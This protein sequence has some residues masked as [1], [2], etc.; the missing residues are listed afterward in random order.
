M[1]FFSTE[2]VQLIFTSSQ[3][4]IYPPL[5]SLLIILLSSTSL[6]QSTNPPTEVQFDENFIVKHYFVDKTLLL[7]ELFKD[8]GPDYN[9][10]SYPS[11]WGKTTTLQMIKRFAQIEIGKNRVPLNWNQTKA[12]QLFKNLKIARHP[13]V[14]EKHMARYAV[15]HLDLKIDIEEEEPINDDNVVRALNEVIRK[16]YFEYRWLVKLAKNLVKG[17]PKSESITDRALQG[18]L[19]QVEQRESILFLAQLLKDFF[20][21]NVLLLIDDYD[22]F[23]N[24]AFVSG[25]KYIDRYKKIVRMIVKKCFTYGNL[26]ISHA[27]IFG[28]SS[29]N[30]NFSSYNY[31]KV[32]HYELGNR[33]FLSD[34]RFGAFLGF[35]END[36]NTLCH[37]YQCT[38]EETQQLRLWY[39]G[40]LTRKLHLHDEETN[41]LKWMDVQT[42]GSEQRSIYN[43]YSITQYFSHRSSSKKMTPVF[44]N[45]WPQSQDLQF[46]YNFLRVPEFRDKFVGLFKYDGIEMPFDRNEIPQAFHQFTSMEIFNDQMIELQDAENLL[47]GFFFDSG[48]LCYSN[49]LYHVARIP[50]Y[51]IKHTLIEIL[52]DFYQK[53]N[54]PM[55]EIRDCFDRIITATSWNDSVIVASEAQEVLSRTFRIISKPYYYKRMPTNQDSELEPIRQVLLPKGPE[56]HNIIFTAALHTSLGKNNTVVNVTE[57]GDYR[58]RDDILVHDRANNNALIIRFRNQTN[59]EKAIPVGFRRALKPKKNIT[60]I[61]FLV[62]KVDQRQQVE[63][64]VQIFN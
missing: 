60:K 47:V 15:I 5:S 7:R 17:V 48:Y 58:E 59:M 8:D 43:P 39:N 46:M 38:D 16:S 62:V 44:K 26:Y 45:F 63:T 33:M 13:E 24:K 49:D 30:Y 14:L 42:F 22:Y 53:R 31:P 3:I 11:K 57:T 21:A 32:G 23:S 1:C 51:E 25:R 2:F 6:V 41:K 34:D 9:Y 4:M 12:Y 52:L 56:L 27:V 18:T 50:N 55:D 10:I 28:S 37:K 19:D 20:R 64:L 36:V 61:K 35:T 40:Y 54:M 29:L